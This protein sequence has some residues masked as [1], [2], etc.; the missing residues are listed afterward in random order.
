MREVT[1]SLLYDQLFSPGG[2]CHA[3]HMREVTSSL[4]YDRFAWLACRAYID[5]A[6]HQ[7]RDYAGQCK[8]RTGDIQRPYYTQQ[9]PQDT[10]AAYTGDI[11]ERTRRTICPQDAPAILVSHGA[12]KQGLLGDKKTDNQHAY[13]SN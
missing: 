10:A 7:Q 5:P 3:T 13:H 4:L 8:E 12:L 2:L 1:S 11:K 9:S 6:Q